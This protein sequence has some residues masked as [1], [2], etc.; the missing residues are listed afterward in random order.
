MK[1]IETVKE[2]TRFKIKDLKPGDVFKAGGNYYV[3]TR[4]EDIPNILYG[5]NIRTDQVTQ[6]NDF[7][8]VELMECE[9]FIRPRNYYKNQEGEV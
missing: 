1:I 2:N 7:C 4:L 5:L 9:V 3:L 8:D 6:L